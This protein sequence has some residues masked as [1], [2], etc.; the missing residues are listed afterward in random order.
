MTKPTIYVL[1]N[2]IEPSDQPVVNLI[3]K[4]KTSFPH[5]NFVHFDPTEELP[6]NN[7]N[8]TIIDTVI[9]IKKV[10]R[11]D[12]ARKWQLSPRV[13]AHDFDLPLTLGISK[14]L[15]RINK[16]TIIGIPLNVNEKRIFEDLKKYL[17]PLKL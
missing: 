12:D 8:L 4:L 10:T 9:G 13:T 2:P 11:F 15:G 6:L 5:I 3:P 16:V 14:K 17:Q 7:K 1:G